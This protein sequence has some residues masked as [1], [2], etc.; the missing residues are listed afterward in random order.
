MIIKDISGVILAGGKN[1]RYPTIKSYIQIGDSTIIQRNLRTLKDIF[2]EVF[3]STNSP[4]LYFKLSVPL[5]GDMIPSRGPMSGLYTLL[6]NIKNNCL[7]VVACDMPFIKKSLILF[8]CEKHKEISKKMEV[9]A[10]IP[11]YKDEPQPLFGIYCKGVLS[12]LKDSILKEKT[13]VRRFLD[14]I[15]TN[16][17]NHD[18]FVHLDPEGLSFININT[19]EDY[20]NITNLVGLL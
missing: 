8:I 13:S 17:I 9:D 16:Y 14:E 11:V 18:E 1:T 6:S 12:H 4:E 19:E 20:R 15:R 5:F 3:I 2:E 7:F 10:T